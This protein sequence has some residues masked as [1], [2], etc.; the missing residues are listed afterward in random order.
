MLNAIMTAIDDADLIVSALII[1]STNNVS[2]NAKPRAILMLN[3]MLTAI[4]DA[5]LIVSALIILSTNNVSMNAKPRAI[6]MLNAM[7]TAI[8]SQMIKRRRTL[9][10][11]ANDH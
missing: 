3:A 7:L 8:V 10:V 4:D 5:D 1:L 11:F 6:L 9:Y 2:M